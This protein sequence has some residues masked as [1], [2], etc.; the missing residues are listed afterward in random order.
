MTGYPL[1]QDETTKDD[2]LGS[3]P[4]MMPAFQSECWSRDL[5]GF[6]MPVPVGM[7]VIVTVYLAAYRYVAAYRIIRFGTER[8]EVG[9]GPACTSLCNDKHQTS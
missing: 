9:I 4:D 1:L 6:S 5:L 8:G 2:I 7:A 3:S